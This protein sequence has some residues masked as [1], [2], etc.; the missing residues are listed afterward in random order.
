MSELRRDPITGRWNITVTDAALGPDAYEVEA[1]AERGGKCPFC[2]GSEGLTPV[3]IF[4]LRPPGSASNGPGWTLRVIPNKFPALRIEGDMARRGI[5]LYD[6]CS[7]IGAHEVIVETPDHARQL[8]DL[9]TEEVTQVLSAYRL[10]SLDLRGDT[11]LRYTL[12]FKNH[13]LSAGATLEHTHSQL[14]A[15]PIVPKRVREELKGAGAY[16]DF[17]ERCVFCDMLNQELQ[18]EE[19]VVAENRSFVALCPFVS[20]APFELWILPK[21]HQGDFAKSTDEELGDCARMLRDVLGRLRGTLRNPPYNFIVHTAP[22]E[23]REREEY[24]WHLEVMPKLTRTAGFEWG[25]GFYINS[26][27][28]ELAAKA[29]REAQVAA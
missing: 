13:G 28:P 3:E 9:S 10:R 19:R 7:G 22:I 5:G 24:H 29:L 26:T 11:R 14:I 27:P 17:R 23:P 6:Q 20:S 15:L 12:I 18:D 2:Y 4:A 21:G 1:P 16:Y 8:A 25:T